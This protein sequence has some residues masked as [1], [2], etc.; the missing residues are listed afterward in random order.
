MRVRRAAA[1]L[2]AAALWAAAGPGARAQDAEHLE[3]L[4]TPG[5]ADVLED[6]GP[7]EGLPPPGAEELLGFLPEEL[8]GGLTGAAGR[9]GCPEP[10]P[11]EGPAGPAVPVHEAPAGGA[12]GAGVAVAV[13]D[14]GVA[15][16]PRL[17]GVEPV[18]DLVDPLDPDPHRDCDGHGT[19]V[20]GIIAARPGPDGYAGIAPGARILSVRQSTAY[21]EGAGGGTLDGLA[22]ALRLAIEAG[23]GVVNVSVVACLPAGEAP[24]A[25][26]GEALAAAEEAGAL[27]VAAAGNI[28][29]DC[30]E[31]SVAHPAA[32]ET[33]LAVAA[34]E[35]GAP[36]GYSLAAAGRGLAAE[37]HVPVALSP[38]EEGLAG[39]V[40]VPAGEGVEERE[41]R[42]TS[43]AAPVVTGIAALLKERHPEATAAQLRGH[44]LRAAAAPAGVVSAADASGALLGEPGAPAA[45]GP[46]TPAG[47]GAGWSR[48]KGLALAAGTAGAAAAALGGV[49]LRLRPA[50]TSARAARRASRPRGA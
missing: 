36:A 19:A 11:A 39:G 22:E 2:L 41:F 20:A 27:V 31:G 33:V 29:E 24:P 17:G 47:P 23:A 44:L 13:I 46:A 43:F 21:P 34:L 7:D 10:I 6:F 18:A 14:T 4:E 8:A 30:P 38:A 1:A 35:G 12:S 50:T 9:S 3:G 26:L 40:A 25:A 42:G 45:P 16:H 15:D 5:E 48:L 49:W 28:G 37:G 32:A